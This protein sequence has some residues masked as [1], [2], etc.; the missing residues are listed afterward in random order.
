MSKANVCLALPESSTNRRSTKSYRFILIILSMP[1]S[2]FLKSD[3]AGYK[4]QCQGLGAIRERDSIVI[5][6]L[7]AIYELVVP[8]DSAKE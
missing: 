8:R 4:T 2:A 1:R 7:E 3:C 5:S 6:V